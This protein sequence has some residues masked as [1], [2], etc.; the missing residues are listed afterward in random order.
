MNPIHLIF[1][2]R[3]LIISA[4]RTYRRNQLIRDLVEKAQWA[5]SID[6]QK[7]SQKAKVTPQRLE[8]VLGFP[9][10]WL[11][12]NA[13]EICGPSLEAMNDFSKKIPFYGGDALRAW[14][15]AYLENDGCVNDINDSLEKLQDL[16]EFW[17]L[18]EKAR[19]PKI[20]QDKLRVVFEDLFER[21]LPSTSDI[22]K[23]VAF[24]NK[25]PEK[26]GH[27]WDRTIE[28]KEKIFGQIFYEIRRR[29][30]NAATVEEVE[31]IGIPEMGWGG[32]GKWQG[33]HMQ[34]ELR[35]YVRDRCDQLRA[36]D[37]WKRIREA[38]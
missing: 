28:K 5:R 12:L 4:R 15:N 24:Y 11:E 3:T 31:S 34:S 9:G 6:I 37:E 23:L 21:T 30:Q 26:Y 1:W 25:L 8:E 36:E 33:L 16:Q 14:V 20:A 27:F 13:L 2:L 29:I 18:L 35:W 32:A 17:Q 38:L 22:E 19:F 10:L 7:A